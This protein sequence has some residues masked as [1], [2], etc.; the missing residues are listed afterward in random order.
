MLNNST[1]DGE[2]GFVN[3]YGYY[4]GT[5]GGSGG[6]ISIAGFDGNT[7]E[8]LNSTISGN[9]TGDGGDGY[10]SAPAGDG[11]SG[12]GIDIRSF[13]TFSVTISNS[14][15]SQ[16]ILG[17]GGSVGTSNPGASGQGAGIS[18]A[19]L[20]TLVNT[21]V[22]DNYSGPVLAASSDL[23]GPFDASYSLIGVD[24]NATI[25]DLGGSQIG[26]TGSPIDPLLDLLND[27]GGHTPTH[28]LLPGSPALDMGDP[29]FTTPPVFDQR[30]IS[31]DRVHNGRI[32]IGAYESQ[33]L[34]ADV[35][36]DR[37]VTGLDFLQLQLSPTI[38]A[39]HWIAQY[40]LTDLP[41]EQL[42]LHV[43]TSLDVVDRYD[44]LTSL[45]EAVTYANLKPGADTINFDSLLIGVPIQVTAGEILISTE[46]TIEGLGP[47]LLIIDAGDGPDGIFGTGDGHRIFRIDDG[48]STR[49]SGLQ[50]ETF[51]VQINNLRLTGGDTPEQG[52]AILNRD[53]LTL[54]NTKVFDNA[55]S[56]GGAIF[57]DTNNSVVN[58]VDSRFSGNSATFGGAI[59]NSDSELN[60]SSSWLYSNTA[61]SHGGGI[62]NSSG[63]VSIANSQVNGNTAQS[64]GGAIHNSR[65]GRV[66]ITNST[67]SS[68]LALNNGGGLYVDRS[69][70]TLFHTTVYQNDAGNDG[71]GL[72][73]DSTSSSS[74]HVSVSNTILSGN[75]APSNANLSGTLTTNTFNLI[76]IAPLLGPLQNNGGI[77][78]THAPLPGSPTIDMG[79]PAFTVPPDNDQRGTGFDRVSGGRIDIGAYE[80]QPLLADVDSDNMVTGLDFLQLQ[81]TPTVALEQ[82]EAEYGVS[83]PMAPPLSTALSAIP[84]PSL[85]HQGEGATLLPA[86][87]ILALPDQAEA[88]SVEAGRDQVQVAEPVDRVFESGE[89]VASES[90]LVDS[91]IL[92]AE[93]EEDT[94]ID[95]ADVE[96]ALAIVFA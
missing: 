44:Q 90:E 85:P 43:N 27:N 70:T 30:G 25:T 96:E 10:Y 83:E 26:T 89:P 76:D 67:L 28:A 66:T 53:H 86:N 50:V 46:L 20:V 68:N 19:V 5:D 49:V 91:L 80:V 22:A 17:D 79:D 37:F 69:T 36:G 63:Q 41:L 54:Y 77:T 60:I 55:A 34:L 11:G 48:N 61:G 78:L 45:R 64:D 42:S 87:T 1:R 18:S 52:G 94:A 13:G 3:F 16:N 65:I 24:T 73:I 81:I 15:I 58:I 39:E 93:V 6:G 74:A 14:T 62:Y 38:S 35:D 12:A 4:P 33:P 21:I 47:N 59:H 57:N 71:G 84:L 32:D 75:T 72:F 8:I 95:E 82:W 23:T 51:H 92:F 88:E 9:S 29:T 7:I 31:F 56:S 2:D 40:G